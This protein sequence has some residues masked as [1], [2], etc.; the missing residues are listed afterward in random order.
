[1]Q[2]IMV[3]IADWELVHVNWEKNFVV[4]NLANWSYNMNLKYHDFENPPE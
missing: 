2:K 1:M 4:D 3:H